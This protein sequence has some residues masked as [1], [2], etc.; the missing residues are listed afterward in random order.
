MSLPS[1]R[2]EFEICL[3]ARYH[4][5]YRLVVQARRLR[6]FIVLAV[7]ILVYRLTSV[8][9]RNS[10][11]A[12]V[13]SMIHTIVLLFFVLG[14][15]GA[16]VSMPYHYAHLRCNNSQPRLRPP[17]RCM[18]C[19][20]PTRRAQISTRARTRPTLDKAVIVLFSPYL[21]SIRL[22]SSLSLQRRA[23]TWRRPRERH[24]SSSCTRDSVPCIVTQSANPV[25][26]QYTPLSPRFGQCICVQKQKIHVKNKATDILLLIAP[27]ISRRPRE[28]PSP[29][30]GPST[31]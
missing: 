8:S 31:T 9:K 28:S 7:S 2:R 18:R 22:L 14:R 16:L 12:A 1:R 21:S 10:N 13:L 29:P 23:L 19:R 26:K 24:F 17:M 30:T 3:R 15:S 4:R 6:S 5:R 20:F 27:S 11:S 25:V